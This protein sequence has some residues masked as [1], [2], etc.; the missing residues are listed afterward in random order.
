MKAFALALCAALPALAV[1]DDSNPR[2]TESS[3]PGTGSVIGEWVGTY[4]CSQGL[5]GI[6]LTI[7]EATPTSTQALFH[8]YADPRNPKVPTGCFTMTGSY[9]PASG[10]LD[11]K[12]E[13]WLLRPGGY[14][15]VGFAGAVDA[16]GSAFTGRVTRAG[17]GEFELGRN[18]SP[19]AAPAAC[20][21]PLPPVQAGQASAGLIGDELAARGA[22]DLEILFEFAQAT[23]LPDSRGQ[24]DELGRVLLTAQ[25]AGRRIGLYGHTDA[26]GSDAVNLPLS[27]ARA[28]AVRRYLVERF[29]IDEGRLEARGFGAGRLRVP[30]APLDAGNRRVEV[31]VLE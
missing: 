27:Q 26:A 13:R 18:P 17:C 20:E 29:R 2:E 23:L 24:L 11:L 8:F 10:R 3:A 31:V 4:T 16:A 6:T 25:F 30:E 7:A 9:D 1:A 12:Q 22:I 19:V 5:T 28:E 15:M 14:S 21:L